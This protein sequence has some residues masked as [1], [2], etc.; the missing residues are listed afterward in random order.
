MSK[1]SAAAA[2]LALA[3]CGL[4]APAAARATAI[5]AVD[6]NGLSLTPAYLEADGGTHQGGSAAGYLTL[7]LEDVLVT[8]SATATG[9]GETGADHG[10][11]TAG[12]SADYWISAFSRTATPGF[13][14][15][16]LT[17][18]VT[19][20]ITN[21]SSV[22]IDAYAL[23]VLFSAFNPGGDPFGALVDDQLVET[24]AFGS[25]QSVLTA[26]GHACS[27]ADPASW[28]YAVTGADGSVACGVASP[29][30]SLLRLTGGGL[31]PGETDLYRAVL[32]IETEARRI[33][34]PAILA[35]ALACLGLLLAA[36][37]RRR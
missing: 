32:S 24:A 8:H 10:G 33:P 2:A 4:L 19:F 18:E 31:L 6:Y 23:D 3:G 37:R 16:D 5:A 27:T 9:G 14:E 25:R 22:T 15:S 26:D 11:G 28:E 21:T 20:G 12:A 30:D 36:R 1:L 29:D 35:T 17:A 7:S 34:E 13:A